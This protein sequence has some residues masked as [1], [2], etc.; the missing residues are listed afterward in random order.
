LNNSFW[1]LFFTQTTLLNEKY[2]INTTIDI[3]FIYV[4][5]VNSKC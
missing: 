2:L 5:I 1:V 3:D 4:K